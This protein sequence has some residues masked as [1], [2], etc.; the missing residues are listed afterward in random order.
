M[1]GRKSK[2][3]TNVKPY[4]DLVK[5]M[6]IDGHTEE[7]IYERLK[8]GKTAWYEYKAEYTE[9]ADALKIGK[10]ELVAQLEQTL[11]QKALEGN[12]TL[13]IFALKNLASDKWGEKID[14]NAQLAAG[15]FIKAIDKFVDKL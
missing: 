7:Q 9:L 8:V 2:Y 13:L 5:S 11:F 6:R 12:P 14:V 10:E 15:D 4:L 3:E 1:A